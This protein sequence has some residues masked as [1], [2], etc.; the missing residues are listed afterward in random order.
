[1]QT[2]GTNDQFI[3]G[4][5]LFGDI[6]AAFV[7]MGISLGCAITLGYFY[8]LPGVISGGVIGS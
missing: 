8:G 2:R 5:G 6:W 7:E 4:Y 3:Y 1:M